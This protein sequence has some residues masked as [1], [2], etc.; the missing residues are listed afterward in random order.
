MCVCVCAFC[1]VKHLDLLVLFVSHDAITCKTHCIFCPRAPIHTFLFSLIMLIWFPKCRG[2]CHPIQHCQYPI[3]YAN[4]R[5]AR[6]TKDAWSFT[7]IQIT[8]ISDVKLIKLN[9]FIQ[10]RTHVYHKDAWFTLIVR[11]T[12]ERISLQLTYMELAKVSTANY[13]VWATKSVSAR[14]PEWK[15]CFNCN[16]RSFSNAYFV[17]NICRFITW[18]RVSSLMMLT[19]RIQMPKTSH[20]VALKF[21]IHCNHH[22]HMH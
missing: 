4:H 16:A 12:C 1:F 21:T 11:C 2:A 3:R 17:L 13:D 15:L 14:R 5:I 7:V 10:S 20:F 6:S 8:W 22:I 18:S 9:D 19:V